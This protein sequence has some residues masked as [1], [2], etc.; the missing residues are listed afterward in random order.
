[1]DENNQNHADDKKLVR[2]V[3]VAGVDAIYGTASS[4]APEALLQARTVLTSLEAEA[5]SDELA[6]FMYDVHRQPDGRF[7][8]GLVVVENAT[9]KNGKEKQRL[10][11][12][13]VVKVVPTG[14]ISCLNGS[15][16]R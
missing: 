12:S 10:Y 1:M 13:S 6:G 11:L 8:W 2:D 9:C 4:L 5:E 14:R 15:K 7:M 16:M 3:T